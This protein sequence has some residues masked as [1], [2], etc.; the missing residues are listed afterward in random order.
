MPITYPLS[1][2]EP[3]GAVNP[4]K[5][6]ANA[7]CFIGCYRAHETPLDCHACEFRLFAGRL[8]QPA[9][10][11][12]AVEAV[13]RRREPAPSLSSGWPSVV[14]LPAIRVRCTLSMVACVPFQTLF[15]SKGL[16]K[17]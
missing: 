2:P 5:A 3:T 17:L 12:R 4:V 1:N 13:F 14:K 10:C 6:P 11:R 16:N 7:F 15:E 8:P 9:R